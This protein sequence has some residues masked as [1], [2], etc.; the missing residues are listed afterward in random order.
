MKLQVN[1]WKVIHSAGIG[2]LL[3]LNSQNSMKPKVSIVCVT[4]NRREL[5]LQC[6][7]SCVKQ[8]YPNLE[9]VVVVN[10]S[11][12]GT[13]KAVGCEFPHA[14]VILTH[15][16][17]GAFPTKN[18]AIAN[19]T[20]DYIMIM[21]DDAYFMESNAI[22]HLVQAFEDE[23]ALGAVTCNIEGPFE[24]PI[25]GRDRYINVFK[26][27]FTLMPRQVFTEWVGFYPDLFFRASGETY[28]CSALWDMGKPIKCLHQVKMYHAQTMQGRSDQDWKFYGLKSQILCT[29]MREPWYTIA[30]RL[31]S[32][33]LKSLFL[34]IRWGY[35]LTWVQA[36]LSAIVSI[37]DALQFRR[38]IRW[39]TQK[40]LWRLQKECISDLSSLTAQG[41]FSE[42]SVK[43]LSEAP[44]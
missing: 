19:T 6:L 36:W 25:E 11:G 40:L 8:D 38:P 13:E 29:L 37:P 7:R 22:S 2:P 41:I 33:W 27:G 34:F 4:Y 30:P 31:A 24:N 15:R 5:L 1:Q 43:D 9:I 32:K 14:K 3:S 23:P 10:P 42:P 44:Y 26:D 12:D 17:L 20:G 35:F 16:N 21:D 28:L 39:Q 18:L